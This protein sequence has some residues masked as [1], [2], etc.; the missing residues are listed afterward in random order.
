MRCRH[1]QFRCLPPFFALL[2]AVASSTAFVGPS[3]AWTVPDLPKADR[4]CAPIPDAADVRFS[5]EEWQQLDAGEI[6]VRVIPGEEGSDHRHV[7]AVG[8]LDAH[9]I[10]LF[11]LGTDSG[12]V[13][14]LVDIIESSK[15]LEARSDGK[16]I[17]NVADVS[18]FVPAFEYT[19][20]AAYLPDRTGQCWAQIEGDFRRNEGSHSF[21]WD[22]VRGRTLAVFTFDL[23][24]KGV[25][26]LI[27][28]RL[29]LKLS[30]RTLPGYMRQ[31][32]A[33][34]H[35][36]EKVDPDRAAAVAALWADL[37]PRLRSGELPSRV[38]PDRRLPSISAA[39]NPT[40]IP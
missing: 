37:E 16:V 27:P 3:H 6:I 20:E 26:R 11:D 36:M 31:L 14:D 40:V 13:T 18:A 39:H 9:P 30:G 7:E 32:E 1:T 25:L 8:F 10:W 29:I 17:H 19:L 38:W 21:L 22:P 35:R 23:G 24:L 28:D 12:L 2:I 33:E 34:A 4:P 15:V 5:Q